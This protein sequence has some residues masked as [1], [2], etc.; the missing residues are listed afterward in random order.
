VKEQKPKEIFNISWNKEQNK[1]Y[2]YRQAK[3]L[4][5]RRLDLQDMKNLIMWNHNINHNR[6][7]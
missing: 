5:K 4:E 3:N 1:S 2:G 7:I 6:T